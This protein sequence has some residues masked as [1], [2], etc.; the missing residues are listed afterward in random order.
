MSSIRKLICVG[1]IG[2]LAACEEGAPNLLNDIKTLNTSTANMS[3]EQRSLLERQRDYARVRTTSAAVGAV[4][5]IAACKV[6]M[7]HD[8]GAGEMLVF[9]ALGTAAGFSGG[10]Y[11]TRNNSNFQASQDAL[12]ADIT[13]ARSEVSQMESNVSA[14]Q[15]ALNFQ[16]SEVTRLNRALSSGQVDLATY[17]ASL[18]TM[19]GDLNST[20]SM[21]EKGEADIQRLNQS[22]AR[23]NSAGLSTSGLSS[24]VNQQQRRVNQLRAI[25]NA[26]VG[27]I[28]SVPSN[29][30]V[31][32]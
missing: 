8:C 32:A 1:L 25:E 23:Y 22:I 21:R 13:A 12:N 30:R 6:S 2:L 4:A 19:Q 15:G 29:V 7:G 11:L 28:N 20:N 31:G 18:S 26:M 3:T 10:S 17:R 5:G 27:V 9:M 24:A 14:A 16:R